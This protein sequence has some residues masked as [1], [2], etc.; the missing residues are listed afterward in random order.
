MIRR[1]GNAVL[2]AVLWVT[3]AV[4][5]SIAIYCLDNS[6]LWGRWGMVRVE[7]WPRLLGGL[8]L[9]AIALAG[10]IFAVVKSEG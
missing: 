7:S 5:L 10:C 1:L 9:L 3:W 4:V 2:W 8:G 6:V